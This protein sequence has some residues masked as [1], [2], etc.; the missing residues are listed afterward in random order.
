MD[1]KHSVTCVTD[2]LQTEAKG[3]PRGAVVWYKYV[4]KPEELGV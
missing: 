1:V 3:D 2:P 4:A